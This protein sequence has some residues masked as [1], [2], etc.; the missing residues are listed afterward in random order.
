M[1]AGPVFVA[2]DKGYDAEVAAFNL[3]NPLMPAIAVGVTSVADVQSVVRFAGEHR[4]PVSV[5]STGHQV[6]RD[7]R[8]GTLIST[9]RMGEVRIDAANRT[10]WAEAGARWSAV[11]A[12]ASEH[13]LAPMSGSALSVGAVGYTL[14]GGLSPVL[15]RSKGYAADHVARLDVVTADGESRKVAVD[16]EPDLFWA[17]RGGKGNFGVV[18]ACEFRLF[19]VTGFY[20]G[21]VYFPGERMPEVLHVWRT[22]VGT[23]PEQATS[24][25]AVKRLL[26]V[27]TLPEPVRGKFVLHVRFAYLGAAGDGERLFAP[28]RAAGA[29]LLDEVRMRAYSE[30]AL[31]HRDPTTHSAFYDRTAALRD[32]SPGALDKFVE[33]VG[34]GS[35]C[36]LASVEIRA[37]GG[38]LDRE[39]AAPNAVSTRGIPYL[40]FGLGVGGPEQADQMRGYLDR[41]VQELGTVDD[42]QAVN[43]LSSDQA[44]TPSQLRVVYGAERYDRLARI[45]QRLD[46]DNMFRMNHNIAAQ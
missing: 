24:S 45:K 34:P 7:G 12:A 44:A 32:L 1:V 31:I 37:L 4:L 19:E 16:S 2:N 20:G 40:L 5:R 17:L 26:D 6:V 18:T 33:L 13:G 11:V 30:T 21:G 42:R 38:A 41:I 22:W 15:S 28:I 29:P 14:G 35:G 46:P 9:S 36:P 8:E 27:P 43:F 10:A 25:I 23:L 39:P 3:N